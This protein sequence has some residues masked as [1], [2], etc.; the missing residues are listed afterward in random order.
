M[1]AWEELEAEQQVRQRDQ[2]EDDSVDDEGAPLR[3][4]DAEL[5]S[6][7]ERE[8]DKY[9]PPDDTLEP[10]QGRDAEPHELEFHSDE[11]GPLPEL[12]EEM[13]SHGRIPKRSRYRIPEAGET[14]ESEDEVLAEE[15]EGEGVEIEGE[16][17]KS[18]AVEDALNK[19]DWKQ[20]LD[21][22][23]QDGWRNENDLTNLVF[24]GKHKE[25][26]GRKLDPKKNKDDAKLATEGV[27]SATR[28]LGK[29]S[30]AQETTWQWAFPATWSLSSTVSSGTSGTKVQGA[31]KVAA[32]EVLSTPGFSATSLVAETGSKWVYL[33]SG[34][35]SS[36][37]IGTD[38]F[39]KVA[40][41]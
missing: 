24:F 27:N 12:E 10:V 26:G 25:L 2:E 29:P 14:V 22:A 32:K 8:H 9:I 35:V 41:R 5:E 11:E 7:E 31:G 13:P 1:E 36:Y 28:K 17:P 6:P 30:S 4:D 37:H 39:S 20:A 18:A 16:P 33:S 40:L 19:N 3:V 15:E 21:Q 38:D 34:L 23:I